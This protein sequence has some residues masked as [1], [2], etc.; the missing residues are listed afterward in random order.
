MGVNSLEAFTLRNYYQNPLGKG[1]SV[2]SVSTQKKIYEKEFPIIE[3]RIRIKWFKT[4]KSLI[5]HIFFPSRSVELEYDV[6]M[7]F[8]IR[9]ITPAS[10]SIDIL[11]V[12]VFSNCPSFSY[13]YANVFNHK[14]ILC[15]WLRSK[16]NKTIFKKLPKIR[17]PYQII[18]FERSLYLSAMYL[19]SHGR[20]RLQGIMAIAQPIKNTSPIIS[21]IRTQEEIEASY[22]RLHRLKT[23]QEEKMLRRKQAFPPREQIPPKKKSFMGIKKVQRSSKVTKI[24]K[25]K[26]V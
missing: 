25:T 5:A 16:Y 7:E 2:I 3:S 22:N 4:K 23:E 21:E 26:K 1:A 6:I 10:H 13:T 15:P 18:S 8:D 24:K 17:N 9:D 19:L 14:D 20:H 12:R 11:P